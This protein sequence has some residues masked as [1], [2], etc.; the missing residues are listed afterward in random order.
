MTD[1][2]DRQELLDLI[3]FLNSPRREVQKAAI[4]LVEGLAG[5]LEGIEKLL[6]ESDKLLPALLR[7]IGADKDLSKGA[8]TSL[9]NLSQ[10]EEAVAAL[11]KLKVVG[12]IMDYLREDNNENVGLLIMLLANVT[13]SD[14]GCLRLLQL[15]STSLAGFNVAVLLKR[16]L[17]SAGRQPDAHEHTAL[18]LTNIT[19]LQQGRQLLLEPGRG[20]L[21]ALVSQLD[22]P[23]QMRRSGCANAIRNCCFCAEEDKTLGDLLADRAS[24]ENLLDLL[25]G[26]T[27]KKEGDAA[28]RNSLA[29]SVE[30]LVSTEQGGQVLWDLK[31]PEM[32][33]KGY[34]M[35]E[36]PEVCASMERIAQLFLSDSGAT[37]DTG[38]DQDVTIEEL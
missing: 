35:E 25:C 36:D 11:V 10:K 30:M 15:D 7:L 9:I 8:L 3:E 13:T 34:E 29:E 19:R 4:G 16:F 23:S 22:S 1:S 28:V 18:V 21:Q 31:A 6:M 2:N 38:I 24:L 27:R 14:S 26:V 32:L 20:T 12:R 33:R 5:S 17:D 37:E